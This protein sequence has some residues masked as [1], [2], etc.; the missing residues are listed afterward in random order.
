MH[1]FRKI[2]LNSLE[3]VDGR[4]MLDTHRRAGKDEG[5]SAERA[6]PS[7]Y[8]GIGILL[9]GIEFVQLGHSSK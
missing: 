4:N 9:F 6:Y 5:V 2:F 7:P 3:R 1:I 8:S